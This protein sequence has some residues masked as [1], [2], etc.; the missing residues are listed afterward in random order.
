VTRTLLIVS[1]GAEALPGIRLAKRMGLHVVVS[2]GSPE[3][4]GLA[5]ADDRLIASTYDVAATVNSAR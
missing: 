5:E 1:G 4:P 2:D 3:A